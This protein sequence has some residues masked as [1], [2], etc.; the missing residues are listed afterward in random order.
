[1]PN[2]CVEYAKSARAKCT[3]CKI[4]IQKHEIRIGTEVQLAL[5]SDDPVVSWQ[6]RHLCCFT[7]RQIKNAEASGAFGNINGYDELASDDKALVDDLKMGKLVD[8]TELIGRIGNAE[9]ASASS[10]KEK[11]TTDRTKETNS[12]DIRTRKRVKT[13]KNIPGRKS[14]TTPLDDED[15]EE[16]EVDVVVSDAPLCP[17][18][19]IC[20]QTQPLH[21]L[22]FRHGDGARPIIKN[23][24]NGCN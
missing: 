18:G 13:E 3:K 21:H 1:M 14:S 15:T 24:N 6:W 22:Q 8:K 19:E 20:F 4:A 5:G 7:D 11:T 17:Y 2:L 23:K 16:F 12:A 10:K 9:S